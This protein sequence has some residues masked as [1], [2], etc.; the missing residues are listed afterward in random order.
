MAVVEM[1]KMFFIGLIP[2]REKILDYMVRKGAVEINAIESDENEVI[3]TDI[4]HRLHVI[5]EEM[6]TVKSAVTFLKKYDKTKKKLFSVRQEVLESDF[7]RI[8]ENKKQMLEKVQDILVLED[9]IK[10]IQVKINRLQNDKESLLP[11]SGFDIPLDF[12]GTD[13]TRMIKGN[14]PAVISVVDVTADL[15]YQSDM[16]HYELISQDKDHSYIAVICHEESFKDTL[17]TLKKYGFNEFYDPSFKG[18][19]ISNIQQLDKDIIGLN[20]NIQDQQKLAK[21]F[22]ERLIEV[23]ILY[24]ALQMERNLLL[25]KNKM[26]TTK[27]TFAFQ[28]WVPA[29]LVEGISQKLISQWNCYVYAVDAQED[30]NF[31]V[32][33]KNPP[34]GQSVE[35]ITEM[36][37]LPDCREADPNR[38]M[39][40]FYIMFFGLML[41]DA[42]YGLLLAAFCGFV[43]WKY[44]LEAGTKQ[45]LRMLMYC[46]IATIFWGAMFGGWFGDLLSRILGGSE[47]N[48]AVWFNPINDPERL[49][50]WS[51][52]FGVIHTFTGIGIGGYNLIREKKYLDAIIE[53][54]FKYILFTGLIMVVL[55]F[56]P[57]VGGAF[58]Q[59]A[60]YY[61][62]YVFLVGL[63]LTIL[64]GINGAK[65]IIAGLFSGVAKLYDV[66]SFFSDIL[67]YAR[68]L[69]L[70]LATGVVG[71]IVNQ[72]AVM[73]G[74]SIGG[75]ILFIAVF[76][77]GHTLNIALNALSAYVHSSRLQYIEFFGK[78]YKGGG[79]AFDPLKMDT[80]Y[81]KVKLEV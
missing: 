12:V 48:V 65:N 42:G 1:K 6:S 68:I 8:A 67:S 23:K 47:V 13:Q 76:L 11:W 3:H 57:S 46:G 56:V 74:L 20:Q 70:G 53:T 26:I 4:N 36:Y 14:L 17:S 39:A 64:G 25:A 45:F 61:G 15:G 43:V 80:E 50:L 69:A 33:L 5:E 10:A 79:K 28:S 40:F 58:A 16:I 78:F 9:G 35:M 41:G 60:A 73:G 34:I 71:A 52:I 51:L 72:M 32:L 66:V 63:I 37:S 81:I 77:F 44:E 54:L 24:D 27:S 62:K 38:I 18:T 22:G 29:D 75:V 21:D 59:R 19:A 49:L 31:P 2:D 55:P 7:L 30:E